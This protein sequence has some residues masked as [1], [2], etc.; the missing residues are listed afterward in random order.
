MPA[1]N[2]LLLQ[3]AEF[4]KTLRSLCTKHGA[5]LIFDEVISGFR[6][7]PGGAAA[8]YSIKPD[9]AT[10]GKVIGGGM[11]VGGFAGPR[12]LMKHLSP[13][14]GVYQ[15]GT[16]SGNPVAMTA[17]LTTLRVL[18]KEDGWKRLETLGAYLE[19][20]LTE[21]ARRSARSTAKL[22][23]LGSMFWIAWH[24]REAPRSAE[25]LDANAAKVYARVFHSL[26]D[27]GIAL[28]PSAFEIAFLS[29]AHTRRDID[30]LAE[31]L[32][33]ALAHWRPSPS[34]AGGARV[35]TVRR[36][37]TKAMQIGFLALLSISAATVGWWM[38]DHVQYARSVEQRFA[39]DPAVA[40]DSAARI[41]RILWEG[42][43]FLVV[44]IGGMAVLTRT[45]RHDA[46]LRR[47]QQNF[48]AAV[49]HEFKSPLASIQL[50]AETLVLRSRDD[51]GK[52]LGT[53]ILED[54]ERLL[55]MIDNLLDTT[56]LEE[57]RQRLTPQLDESPRREQGR[58]RRDRRARALE[59]R[60]GHA[61]RRRTIS[62]LH[63]DPV[64][65]ETGLRN[66]LDNA[67]KSCVAAK[68]GIDRGARRARR[69]RHHARRQRR[70]ARL[71]ARGR[72]DDLREVPSA[73]RRAAARDAGHGAR[74][75][76][77]EAARRAVGRHRARGERRPR[78]RRDGVD[79]LAG[80]GPTDEG[81]AARILVVDDE[82]HLAAGIR[83]N[84]E[85]EGYR[86]DVAHD[87][88]AGLERL[89]AEPFDLVVLD[90]MMPNM[91]GLELCAQLRR[92][93]IQTP[94]LF[95]TV[96]GAAEDRVRGFEAGGDDYL[97]EAVSPAGA[98][99]ARRGD[100]A[101]QLLVPR[102]ARRRRSS[103]AA[104]ASTSRPTRRARGTARSTR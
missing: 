15:A 98:A 79:A 71:S 66:L 64:V 18:Q 52:R 92:D 82:A 45:L 6:L 41:N 93:G 104:I 69:E 27:Q 39:S 36:D 87:G 4:L 23:R 30:R 94:V 84:L 17:G 96:K 72:G 90:V 102:R 16:L 81:A 68:S 70:R 32:R 48:L 56:R 76:H 12:K 31:G 10:F 77:R 73:R 14:G 57:G 1:N 34:D 9:L 58:D 47:R 85:A 86:A 42:G 78:A 13:E 8:H 61:R 91:D 53:R 7:G 2:G 51:D 49:S 22:V 89:R 62:T 67:L 83:E 75:L 5:L 19:Q 29:L 99:A 60:G 33:A 74:A 28:A 50:A 35:M 26:L 44:L 11:P 21:R 63:V 59:R 88:T 100:P 97:A 95:L 55:R 40:E 20:T 43:F 3:R 103:S 25:A 54:G 38:Y 24:A 80:G 101:P 65:V 46:E 37:P